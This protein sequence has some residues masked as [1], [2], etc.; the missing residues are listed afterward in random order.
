M[1]LAI[2]KPQDIRF[3]FGMSK[4]YADWLILHTAFLTPREIRE[5]IQEFLERE[6]HED[7]EFKLITMNR[8]VLDMVKHPESKNASSLTYEDVFIWKDGRLV[9]LLDLYDEDWLSHF[10]LGDLFDRNAL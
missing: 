9:P 6:E 4:L 10:A 8:T 5:V 7:I 2:A 1:K 3:V